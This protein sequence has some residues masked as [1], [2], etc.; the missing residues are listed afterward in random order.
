MQVIRRR[1][2]TVALAWLLCQAATVAAFVPENCC[3]AHIDERAASQQH[4][5]CHETEPA[6]PEPGDLCPMHGSKSG[7]DCVMKNTCAGPSQHL[8]TLF[9]YFTTLERPINTDT[10]LA[11]TR[12]VFPSAPPSIQKP[13]SPDAPPPK[14]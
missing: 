9:A 14:A 6:E 7:D 12:L 13:S 8:T 3:K 11:A 10:Q 4:E 1:V 2:R 5:A